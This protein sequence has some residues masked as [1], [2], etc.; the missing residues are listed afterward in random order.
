MVLVLGASGYLGGYVVRRLV[1]AGER[2]RAM[3]RTPDRRLP[4]GSDYVII[5]GAAHYWY[6]SDR[7]PTLTI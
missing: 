2:V 3:S 4:R 1:A 5:P 7:Q 6:A